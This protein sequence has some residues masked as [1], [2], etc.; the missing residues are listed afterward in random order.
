[1]TVT[2]AAEPSNEGAEAGLA[3][4][5][6]APQADPPLISVGHIAAS[7]I[8]RI[9]SFDDDSERPL[10]EA[11]KRRRYRA[12]LT[13]EAHLG[14]TLAAVLEPESNHSTDHTSPAVWS[15]STPW[16]G[17]AGIYDELDGVIRHDD[18]RPGRLTIG[19]E[20]ALPGVTDELSFDTTYALHRPNNNQIAAKLAD[21]ASVVVRAVSR[22]LDG[23]DELVAALE[24]LL[25]AT[26]EADA[27]LFGPG[28]THVDAA[29]R[30]GAVLVLPLDIELSAA[31]PTA[32]P[33]PG[34]HLPDLSA[35]FAD[36]PPTAIPPGSLVTVGPD[37][38]LRLRSDLAGVALRIVLPLP[39]RN[40]LWSQA[41]TV[42]RY[43]PLLRADL[44][45]D[46]DAPIESYGGSLYER[47]GA[48]HAE[49][50]LA[51]GQTPLMHALASVR[52]HVPTRSTCGLFDN[53]RA[54][55]GALP[56]L[57][58]AIPGGAVLTNA[59]DQQV[60]AASGVTLR[61]AAEL[62]TRLIPHLDGEVFDPTPLVEGFAPSSDD[63]RDNARDPNRAIEALKILL[64]AEILAVVA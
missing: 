14:R 9:P 25:G 23:M 20:S 46:L 21:G 57:R 41:A 37:Q 38:S 10:A 18:T 60:L 29:N 51:L 59:D 26:T 45:T 28:S 44:P 6:S 7:D 40:Q 31:V 2:Q 34:G 50:S 36:Q 55:A 15:L 5:A 3:E 43:H 62:A 48:F 54:R 49:A 56:T 27:I 4:P 52:A 22:H 17:T 53:Q 42:A 24:T 63:S 13:V 58:A 47:P 30:G 33:H 11:N 61:I 19:L 12:A 35:A 8:L 64:E 1:M 32:S 39:T 16:T